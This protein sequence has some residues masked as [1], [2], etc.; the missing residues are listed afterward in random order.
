MVGPSTIQFNIV[1]YLHKV[2]D[3]SPSLASAE[4]AVLYLV[5]LSAL[6][7]ARIVIAILPYGLP[8]LRAAIIPRQSVHLWEMPWTTGSRARRT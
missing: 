1:A 8:T 5:P 3:H 2:K 7:R 6:V 4:S